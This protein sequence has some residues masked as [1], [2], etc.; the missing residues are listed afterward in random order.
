YVLLGRTGF[1]VSQDTLGRFNQIKGRD[2]TAEFKDGNIRQVIVR[3]NGESLYFVF[4]ED[5]LTFTGINRIICSN[6]LIRFQ[7]GQVYDLNFYVQPDASFIPP[8]ELKEDMK[9]L[10][11]FSW[12][13][14]VRPTRDDVVPVTNAAA[15]TRQSP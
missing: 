6:I 14:D 10:K 1:V 15:D 4:D 13:A 11:G 12:R 8:H 5:D 2:M 3:G 7:E 9:T